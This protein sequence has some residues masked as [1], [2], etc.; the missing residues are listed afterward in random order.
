M[1]HH[2][3]TERKEVLISALTRMSLEDLMLK[4]SSQTQV[5]YS[6]TP[7]IPNVRVGKSIDP[8]SRLVVSMGWGVGRGN[9]LS[10]MGMVFPLGMMKI[11]WSYMVVMMAHLCE[12]AKCH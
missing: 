1:E 8:Y 9:R 2:P 3:A 7:F 11:F 10:L 6:K 12:C 5:T 4:E